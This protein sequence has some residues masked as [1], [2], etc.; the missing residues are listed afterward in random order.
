MKTAT[1]VLNI[2]RKYLGSSESNGGHIKIVDKYNKQK[3]L[4]VGYKVK[5]TDDWCD[6]FVTVV[7][8]EAGI[9]GL[10]GAE[11]GVERHIQLFKKLGIWNEDGKITP[12]AGY[13]ITYNWDDT[14]QSND[15]FA[16]HIGFVESVSNGMVTTIEGNYGNM[17]KRRTIPVGSGVIRGY[18][19]P[20]YVASTTPAKPATSKPVS[21]GKKFN[22]PK[23]VFRYRKN[24]PMR[25]GQDVLQIQLALSSIYFYPNVKSHDKGCDGYYGVM[26]ADAVKRFQSMNG[27]VADGDYGDKTRVKLESKVNK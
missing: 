8:I 7:G 26:T 21:N 18:A 14:T 5:Y 3:T 20:K 17:V 24:E 11:C 10:I 13:I 12:K 27:L 15:G 9:T 19:M 25:T 2:A 22:L 6:V 1:E 23:G 4:P 16:D